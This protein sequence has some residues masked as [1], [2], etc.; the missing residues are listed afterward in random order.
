MEL[1]RVK[2]RVLEGRPGFPRAYGPA[3]VDHQPGIPL[4]PQEATRDLVVIFLLT[5]IMFFLSSYLTPF[6]GPPPSPRPR[7]PPWEGP[8]PIRDRHGVDR[9]DL[10]GLPV[11]DPGGHLGAV[12]FPERRA[13]HSRHPA[14]VVLRDPSDPRRPRDVHGT[15][16]PRVPADAT[17]ACAQ[18]DG[19]GG[20]RV[21]A[22]R[23]DPPPAL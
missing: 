6:L 3:R 18:R 21:R 12:A 9:G 19:P 13:P 2:E 4:F 22:V 8:D 1:E 5:A 16:A 11:L 14:D 10:H 15:P 17:L 20:H 7:G 23:G